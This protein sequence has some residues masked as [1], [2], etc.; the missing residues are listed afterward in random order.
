MTLPFSLLDL[1]PIAE[2]AS[3]AEALENSRQL[4]VQA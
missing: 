1:A 2:G 3:L 4:A